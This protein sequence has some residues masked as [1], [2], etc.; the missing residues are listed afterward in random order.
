MSA[1]A[2]RH[3]RAGPLAVAAAVVL[4]GGAAAPARA[5]G[6]AQPPRRDSTTQQGRRRAIDIRAT[7]PAPEVVTIRPREIPAFGRAL[8]VPAV[9]QPPAGG[10][11]PPATVVIFPGSLPVPRPAAPAPPRRPDTPTPPPE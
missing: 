3:L 1:R 4:L 10:D 6:Q 8:L 9:L 2:I 11:Q 5:Q 7:A